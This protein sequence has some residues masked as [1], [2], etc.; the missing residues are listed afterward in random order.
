[1]EGNKNRLLARFFVFWI[2]RLHDPIFHSLMF[3]RE[4]GEFLFPPLLI[5]LVTLPIL[6]HHKNNRNQILS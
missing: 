4:R 5:F 3:P 1:M 6:S 2:T